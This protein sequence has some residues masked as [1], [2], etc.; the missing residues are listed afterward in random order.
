VT[1][2]FHSPTITFGSYTL[3]NA[4][5]DD[6]YLAKY[7]A[8]GNVLWAKSVGETGYDWA[9]SVV[10]DISGNPYITGGFN[11]STIT[12]GSYTLTNTGN[13]DMFLAKYNT[14]GN[15]LWANNA[16]GTGLEIA[17][18]DAVDNS[19]N[20]YVTGVFYPTI[21]FGSYTLTN[22]GNT[23]IFLAK[24]KGDNT[25]INELNNSFNIS[26]FPN[27][28]NSKITFEISEVPYQGKLSIISICGKEL[29]T[30]QIT[31]PTTTIDVSIVPNGIYIV[32]VVGEKGVQVGKFIKQ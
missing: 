15:V 16:E 30:S 2:V 22:T 29:I 1:G 24:L 25:G 6:I 14:T 8:D 32:K 31:E 13:T 11:S 21:A 9:N 27:P 20:I 19:G 12:F 26:I 3:T 28:A 5:Q 17:Y 10:V 7:K 18:S 23:D 4:G